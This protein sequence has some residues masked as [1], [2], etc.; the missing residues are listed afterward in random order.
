[1]RELFKIAEREKIREFIEKN[2]G[3]EQ[4]GIFNVP[5]FESGKFHFISCLPKS[6]LESY[7]IDM[8]LL[9]N[10]ND[11]YEIVYFD[12]SRKMT[13]AAFLP[14]QGFY[15]IRIFKR[16]HKN[17]G[18]DKNIINQRLERAK[19]FLFALCISVAEVNK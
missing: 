5:Q 17:D 7:P 16:T 12:N 19:N 9:E 4:G 8:E 3:I 10:S 11:S 18:E 6:F 14:S 2:Y 13:L 15:N 1:M